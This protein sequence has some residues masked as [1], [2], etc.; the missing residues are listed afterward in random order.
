MEE[1]YEELKNP[2]TGQFKHRKIVAVKVP[3]RKV[4]VAI[5]T[6]GP[7]HSLNKVKASYN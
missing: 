7:I 3:N 1:D 5:K 2:K 6:T 4:I